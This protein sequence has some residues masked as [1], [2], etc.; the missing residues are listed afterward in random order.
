MAGGGAEL[1]TVERMA[2]FVADAPDDT[3]E[4]G[5]AW[6]GDANRFAVS[7]AGDL[8]ITVK[9]A[10]GILAAVSPQLDADMNLS[11]VARDILAG[12]DSLAIT[13]KQRTKAIACM[14]LDPA[15][16]LNPITGP[17]TWAFFW[18]IYAPGLREHVTIDGRFADIWEN[19]MRPWKAYKGIDVGGPNSRYQRYSY[20][21]EDVA[22]CLRKRRRFRTLTAVQVQAIAWCHGKQIELDR[23]HSKGLVRKQ[24]PHRR[25]QTYMEE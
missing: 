23:P 15:Q 12:N 7:L 25:G 9:Q 10:A 21:T 20:A 13:G 3:I 5:L 4:R 22:R 11:W 6:Y 8:G 2:R 24:G 14:T 17:K 18:N 16:V 19:S 1:I